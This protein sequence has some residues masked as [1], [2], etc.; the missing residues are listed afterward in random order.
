MY[1]PAAFMEEAPMMFYALEE[2]TGYK[3]PVIFVHGIN[4]SAQDFAPIIA[5]LDRRIYKPWF[6]HYPSGYDLSQLSEMFY[7]IFLSGKVIPL[8]DTPLIIVAHSM[9]GLVVRDA[10]SRCA[11]GEREAKPN[12]FITIA[13]PMGGHPDAKAGTEAPVVIPSWRSLAPD[14]N[15]MKRMY[16][17]ELPDNL[18]YHLIYAYGNPNTIKLGD[19]SDGVVPLASQLD[20]RAQKEATAQYGFN[21]SHE[22]I[23]KNDNA[24]AQVIKQIGNVKSLFPDEH[25]KILWQGGY[26][27]TL[28]KEYSPMETYF[29]RTYGRYMD[30]LASGIIAPFHPLQV[31]FLRVSRGEKQ[32]ENEFESSW[33][34]FS[35]DFP[36]RRNL[37]LLRGL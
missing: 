32:P 11:G 10:L 19:N 35:K 2:D 20:S 22:G 9:G 24:I 5:K 1:E 7:S 33:S 14:S 18:K 29:I 26:N 34:K 27:V 30:A 31:Q 13:S 36:D 8:G 3:V 15:F 17:R 25:L 21:D 37:R 23:L 28:S 4:G 16:R 12:L 6:F